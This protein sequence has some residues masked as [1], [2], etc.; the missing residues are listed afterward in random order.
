MIWYV[1]VGSHQGS[2]LSPLLL[3]LITEEA[4][5]GC[6]KGGPC[7]LQHTDNLLLTADSKEEIVEMFQEWTKQKD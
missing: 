4:T 2:A 6:K 5:N 1:N 3:I 7:K